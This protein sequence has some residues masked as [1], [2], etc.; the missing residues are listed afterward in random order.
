MNPDEPLR[1]ENLAEEDPAPMDDA[2]GG[3]PWLPRMMD[4][5]RASRSGQ[6]G[7]YC[8]YPGPIDAVFLGILGLSPPEFAG[9]AVEAL[10]A[11]DVPVQLGSWCPST[12]LAL[13]RPARPQR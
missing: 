5:A 12:V 8:R 2:L 6:L 7:N 4:K 11:R 13:L 9:I 1:N 10:E 3:Y